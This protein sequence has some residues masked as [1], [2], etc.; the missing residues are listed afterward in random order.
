MT[1]DLVEDRPG[2]RMGAMGAGPVG[3]PSPALARD[4]DSGSDDGGGRTRSSATWPRSPLCP[5]GT[6]P[7]M[8]RILIEKRGHRV[9][10][11][12]ARLPGGARAE[13]RVPAPKAVTS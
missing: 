4:P 2:L 9:E 12:R 8:A 1:S 11:S 3:I 7:G 10:L 13:G 5:L 6:E